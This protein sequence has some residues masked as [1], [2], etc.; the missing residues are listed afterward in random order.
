MEFVW[1]PP[2]EYKEPL[3]SC[4]NGLVECEQIYAIHILSEMNVDVCVSF[5]MMCPGL[6]LCLPVSQKNTCQ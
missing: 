1:Y 2:V 4:I 6:I 5:E 3:F